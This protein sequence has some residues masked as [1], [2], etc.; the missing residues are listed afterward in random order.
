MNFDV[1]FLNLEPDTPPPPL[2]PLPPPV[3]SPAEP[4]SSEKLKKEFI[5]RGSR[6]GVSP[7]RPTLTNKHRLRRQSTVLD[8]FGTKR[9][10]SK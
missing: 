4:M 3:I 7:E 2:I 9:R 10:G 8:E 1:F 5:R 6:P